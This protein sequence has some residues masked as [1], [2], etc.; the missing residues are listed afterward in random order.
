MPFNLETIYIKFIITQ[1]FVIDIVYFYNTSVTLLIAHWV[2]Y[3]FLKYLK[4]S[5]GRKGTN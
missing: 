4:Y 1:R 3:F 5:D 2:G